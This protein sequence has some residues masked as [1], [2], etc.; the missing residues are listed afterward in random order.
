MFFWKNSLKEKLLAG[1]NT[2]W[3]F[4]TAPKNR[5][6][7]KEP[8][9]P[10]IIFQGRAVKFWGVYSQNTPLSL[11]TTPWLKPKGFGSHD[12]IPYCDPMG[13][14]VVLR[15]PVSWHDKNTPGRLHTSPKGVCVCVDFSWVFLGF[16]HL[17][18]EV[19]GG[20]LFAMFVFERRHLTL[21]SWEVCLFFSSSFW[22]REKDKDMLVTT[23]QALC[24]GQFLPGGW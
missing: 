21:S 12:L 23:C 8:H 5:R 20:S 19:P 10:T 24:L 13:Q 6:S 17:V 9:L 11:G 3:K 22:R 1:D 14:P 15:V 7:Q 18:W 16:Y 2:P 4:N